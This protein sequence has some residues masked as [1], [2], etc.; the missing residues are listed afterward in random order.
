MLEAPIGAASYN[1]EFGR[2]ALTG[3]FR[4]FEAVEDAQNHWGYHKP[5]M[6]AG[7]VGMIDARHVE[8]KQVPVG[9]KVI[10][11]GGPGMTIGLG[12]GS[13]SSVG[14]QAGVKPMLLCNVLMVNPTLK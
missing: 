2:P 7:G 9:A 1:N 4:T 13:A 3:Y 10:V 14:N 12:G 6:L 11:L 8:K 5:I